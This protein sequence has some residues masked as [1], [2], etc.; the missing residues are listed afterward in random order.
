[1]TSKQCRVTDG[2]TSPVGGSGPSYG[3]QWG[4]RLLVRGLCCT[5]R[6]KEKSPVSVSGKYFTLCNATGVDRMGK[7]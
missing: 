2:P 4:G 6:G 1:M 3:A 5:R 7:Q